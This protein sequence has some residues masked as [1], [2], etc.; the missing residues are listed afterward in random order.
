MVSNGVTL[1]AIA[2]PRTPNSLIRIHLGVTSGAW[3]SSSILLCFL[4]NKIHPQNNFHL[5]ELN[6]G[7][8]WD[9]TVFARTKNP[10]FWS[11]VKVCFLSYNRH[12]VCRL[13]WQKCNFKAKKSTR[14]L[15]F[16]HNDWGHKWPVNSRFVFGVVVDESIN[17]TAV[18]RLCMWLLRGLWREVMFCL[19]SFLG[20]TA[21]E[22]IL[23]S[24]L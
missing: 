6:W 18:A 22:H 12:I 3:K 9:C 20:K 2:K 5:K 21:G 15:W 13:W 14:V 7:V 17:V 23:N 19:L 24:P 16:N 1:N 4:C 8:C 10:F 11:T